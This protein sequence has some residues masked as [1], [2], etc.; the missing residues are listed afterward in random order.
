MPKR[1]HL[2]TST[3]SAPR[4]SL[5][6][7]AY[8]EEDLLPRLLDSVDEA[9]ATYRGGRESVEVIVADNASTDATGEIARARRCAVVRVDKR[10]IAAARNGGAAA[11]RGEFLAFTD[12]DMQIHPETFNA[13]EDAMATGRYV[14][15]ATGVRLETVSLGLAATCAVMYPLVWLTRMDTGVVFCRR[16]DFEVVGGY[17][18]N[19]RL[20]EDVSF[21]WT[22]RRLGRTRRQQL[23]RLRRVKAISSTRKFEQFGQ[24]HYFTLVLKAAA[25]SVGIGSVDEL[26]ERYWYDIRR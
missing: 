23:V 22:M 16:E 4:F 17:D 12:A 25:A 9:S 5:I 21:L 14:V 1:Q 20:A 6:I 2:S 26:A 8:N 15:G 7:P 18:E 11:A 10:V 19:L 13:I 24:W 3:P